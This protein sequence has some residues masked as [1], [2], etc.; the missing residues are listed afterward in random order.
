M[1]LT[2]AV[3]LSVSHMRV[4]VIDYLDGCITIRLLVAT[5]I[6][7]Q[8]RSRQEPTSTYERRSA[9]VCSLVKRAA[10]RETNLQIAHLAQ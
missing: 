6:I 7:G 1:T 4:F 3:L 5:V 10:K 8:T 2:P 9:I